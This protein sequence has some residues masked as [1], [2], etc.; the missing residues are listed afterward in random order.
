MRH[1]KSAAFGLVAV[2]GLAGSS[3]AQDVEVTGERID[4]K[5]FPGVTTPYESRILG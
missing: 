1:C 2:C 5:G 3:F 4:P